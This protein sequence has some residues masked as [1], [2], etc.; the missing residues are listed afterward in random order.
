MM[1]LDGVLAAGSVATQKMVSD[2]LIFILSLYSAT[3]L[4]YYTDNALPTFDA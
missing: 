3:Y 1:P 4:L 2:I